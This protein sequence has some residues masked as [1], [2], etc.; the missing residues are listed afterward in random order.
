[1]YLADPRRVFLSPLVV[2]K[3]A[4]CCARCVDRKNIAEVRR[5]LRAAAPQRAD[6]PDVTGGMLA[7]VE[8]LYRIARKIRGLDARIVSGLIAGTVETAL[9][10]GAAGTA[11]R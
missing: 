3:R 7:K 2:P 11:I 9:C 5:A 1:V 4:G 6:R 8:R 10:G